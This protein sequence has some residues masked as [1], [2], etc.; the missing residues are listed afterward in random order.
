MASKNMKLVIWTVH[1]KTLILRREEKREINQSYHTVL[2]C[3]S[4]QIVLESMER[5]NWGRGASLEDL[6]G[7]E[8]ERKHLFIESI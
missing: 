5:G 1:W 2:A 8:G 6:E 4:K 7:M 3:M